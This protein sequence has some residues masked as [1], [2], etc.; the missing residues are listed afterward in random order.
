MNP[1]KQAIKDLERKYNGRI[2]RGNSLADSN[3]WD[4]ITEEEAERMIENQ[5]KELKTW[6]I[7]KILN[8]FVD[9]GGVESAF[10]LEI[11]AGSHL[12]NKERS[13]VVW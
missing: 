3:E 4:E 11:L 13:P 2:Q 12:S 7:R 5:L 6:S 9:P 1:V 8:E 10:I